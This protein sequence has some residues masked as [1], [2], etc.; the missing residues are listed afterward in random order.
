MEGLAAAPGVGHSDIGRLQPSVHP[1]KDRLGTLNT[2]SEVGAERFVRDA[3]EAEHLGDLPGQLQLVVE[4][5]AL[6]GRAPQVIL[7]LQDEQ[8]R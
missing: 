5:V 2:H 4:Y 7:V 8:R 3:W 6:G 1:V